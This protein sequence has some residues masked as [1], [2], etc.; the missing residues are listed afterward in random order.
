VRRLPALAFIAA[1]K[2]ARYAALLAIAL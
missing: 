1:G 2:A